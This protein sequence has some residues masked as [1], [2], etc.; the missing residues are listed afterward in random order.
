M[1]D[2]NGRSLTAFTFSPD[3]APKRRV[4]VATRDGDP[5]FVLA[6]VCRIRTSTPP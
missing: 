4:R 1:A 2:A 5:W 6:D 3:G